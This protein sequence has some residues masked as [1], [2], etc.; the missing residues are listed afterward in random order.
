VQ[1]AQNAPLPRNVLI[2]F[3]VNWGENGFNAGKT[4][5]MWQSDGARYSLSTVAE[6]TGLVGLFK[7][8]RLLQSS[9]GEIANGAPRPNFFTLQRGQ[10]PGKTETA[11]FDWSAGAVNISDGAHSKTVPLREGAQDIL[12]FLFQ[13]AF[14]RPSGD[15][16]TLLIVNGRKTESYAVSVLGEETLDL[17]LG[18]V[19]ALRLT[20]PTT[21]EDDGIDLWLDKNR[22]N[23]PVKIQYHDRKDGHTIELL[24]TELLAGDEPPAV[25]R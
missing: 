3:T 16:F 25:A 22:Y 5:F 14:A 8:D 9:L 13:F 11:V 18:R 12:S 6:Y 19:D 23:L 1:E 15:H 4:D 20:R 21:S 24:A 7:T 2:H 17:P 10:S